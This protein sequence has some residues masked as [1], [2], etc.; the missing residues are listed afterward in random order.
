[1]MMMA[2]E[3]PR[4]RQRVEREGLRERERDG[5]RLP[6]DPTFHH[7]FDGISSPSR[8]PPLTPKRFTA[9]NNKRRR[10][11][12]RTSSSSPP[13]LSVL[14]CPRPHFLVISFFIQKIYLFSFYIIIRI[15]NGYFRSFRFP[16]Q[17]KKKK[18]TVYIPMDLFWKV[19]LVNMNIL[20][21]HDSYNYDLYEL[22]LINEKYFLYEL[23]K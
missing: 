13:P 6:R 4:K 2:T 1:M 7:H 15:E 3:G 10:T 5:E 22:K 11:K 8:S 17:I 23:M 20:F 16:K 9:P 19:A 21:I 18:K 12:Q 14:S